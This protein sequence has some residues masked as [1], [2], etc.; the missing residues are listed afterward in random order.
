MDAITKYIL[1]TLYMLASM[2]MTEFDFDAQNIVDLSNRWIWTIF[3][4]LL[5]GCNIKHYDSI[6]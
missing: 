4:I 1:D 3:Q 5:P 2:H 6:I